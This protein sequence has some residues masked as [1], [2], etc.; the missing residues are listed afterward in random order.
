MTTQEL[1]ESIEESREERRAIMQESG[2][3]NAAAS[4][5]EDLFQCEVKSIIR[6][7]YPDGEKAAEYFNIVEKKRG[8]DSAQRLR[9][10]VRAEWK[11]R[12]IDETSQA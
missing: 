4:A 12:R 2:V 3:E 6:R 10:A 5:D 9:D 8:K 7:F 1:L 11:Q